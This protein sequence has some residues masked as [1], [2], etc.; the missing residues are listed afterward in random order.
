MTDFERSIFDSCNLLADYSQVESDPILP[1]LVTLNLTSSRLAPAAGENQRFCYDVTGVG[2]AGCGSADLNRLVLGVCEEITADEIAGISVTIDGEEQE[3][4]FG[5]GGNVILRRAGGPDR[6]R[7][8]AGLAFY[9]PLEREDSQM[10]VC[11][12]LTEPRPVGPTP[13]SLRGGGVTLSS[14][15][16]C[17]PVCEQSEQPLVAYYRADVCAPVSVTP[18]A[19]AG[20]PVVTPCGAPEISLGDDCCGRGECGFTIRQRLC[21]AV[22]VEFG[23]MAEARPVATECLA[24]GGEEICGGCDDDDQLER[25]GVINRPNDC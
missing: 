8:S 3:V 15:D 9:F 2:E 17:G 22:P 11:F 5:P 16:I 7:G 1:F 19:V 23:A 10:Q 21:V 24:A 14:L 12:E 20:A 25:D 6:G 18:Y 13:V 4:D